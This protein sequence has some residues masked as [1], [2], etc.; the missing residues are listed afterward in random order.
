MGYHGAALTTVGAA[1]TLPFTGLPLLWI[2]LLAAAVIAAGVAIRRLI[3]R[4]EA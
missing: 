3:P 4:E 1:A 2:V